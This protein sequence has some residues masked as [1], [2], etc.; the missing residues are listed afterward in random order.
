M[1]TERCGSS[2]PRRA[3]CESSRW[4]TSVSQADAVFAAPSGYQERGGHR[5]RERRSAPIRPAVGLCRA[6]G[7]RCPCGPT[8][9]PRAPW[10]A[11]RRRR[12]APLTQPPQA[13]T[14]GPTRPRYPPSD[15]PA[16]A[17]RPGNPPRSRAHL[18]RDSP[19]ISRMTPAPPR[20]NASSCSGYVRSEKPCPTPHL[21]SDDPDD[22]RRATTELWCHH[23]GAHSYVKSWNLANFAGIGEGEGPGHGRE[24]EPRAARR[25]ASAACAALR[26]G[27]GPS[28][29]SARGG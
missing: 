24:S 29:R 6:W 22:A 23:G 2:N 7:S 10:R 5:W 18:D 27:A 28:A 1:R 4:S 3:K 11:A 16:I 8:D 21:M 13:P 14:P 17:P 9:A 12:S 15:C 19:A 20:H 26:A 25:P